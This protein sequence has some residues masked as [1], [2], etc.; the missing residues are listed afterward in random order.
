MDA[1]SECVQEA[2]KFSNKNIAFV[3]NINDA[4]IL[5]NNSAMHTG[6]C[7]GSLWEKSSL[8]R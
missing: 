2:V 4:S 5:L 1:V 3:F 8:H 6:H 7:G